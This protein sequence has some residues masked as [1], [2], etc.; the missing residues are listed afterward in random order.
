MKFFVLTALVSGLTALATPA[1]GYSYQVQQNG[2]NSYGNS[3]YTD[4]S[5]TKL[6]DGALGSAS[7][8]DSNY[9]DY[10][11]S[12]Y[13]LSFSALSVAP[14]TSITVY[15]LKNTSAGID[16][17]SRIDVGCPRP[18]TGGPSTSKTFNTASYPDNSRVALVIPTPSWGSCLALGMTIV[19]ANAA[20]TV[21]SEVV[22]Q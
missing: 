1:H 11:T 8:I 18:P 21:L 4:P 15:A 12:T 9:V 2:M 10:I 17:P 7:G 5:F 20:H 14:M 22:I 3:P 19:N 16:I 6:A 13:N